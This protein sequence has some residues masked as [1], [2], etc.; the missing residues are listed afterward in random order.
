VAGAG[1]TGTEVTAQGEL[2]TRAVAARHPALRVVPVRWLLVDRADT[3][4]HG[5]D[6]H[7]SRTAA[8]VLSGR[9]VE[10]RTG[11]SVEEARST[12]V[13]LS[14]G[15]V[16]GSRTLVW[17]VGVRPDPLVT[18]AGLALKHGRLRVDGFLNVPGHPNVFACGDCAAVPSPDDPARLVPATA[19]HAV[20]QGRLV[21]HNLQ[22][23]LRGGSPRAYDH[24]S[25]GF[26][27]D[28]GGWQAAANP[29]RV[30]LSGPLAR[31]V[32]RGYHLAALP[33]GRARTAA[34]WVF[35]AV[36]SRPPVQLGL[37]PGSAVPLESD[38]PEVPRTR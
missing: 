22:A 7:L 3:V 11:T 1:Y 28:L 32:T 12:G 23:A 19:Q 36:G 29:L 24:R 30:P 26:L 21:A 35:S 9:G 14:D 18:D 25:L 10:L 33:S 5:L 20:R 13:R 2:L 8:S 34:D 31:A 38:S 37:V 16:V 27:V 4:L 17:C 15:T 6:G